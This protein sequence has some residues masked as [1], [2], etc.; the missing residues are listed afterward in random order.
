MTNRVCK[1]MDLKGYEVREV[2][3]HGSF[4]VFFVGRAR[5]ALHHEQNQS[6]FGKTTSQAVSYILTTLSGIRY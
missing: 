6:N 4:F 3:G 1:I 5:L 2:F